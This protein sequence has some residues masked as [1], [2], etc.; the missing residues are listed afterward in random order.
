MSRD[1]RVEENWA[2]QYASKQARLNNQYLLVFFALDMEYPGS[3]YRHFD[4]MIRGLQEVESRLNDLGIPFI[5]R[6]GNPVNVIID[7]VREYKVGQLITD[8][9]PLRIKKQWKRELIFRLEIPFYEVDTHNIVP[10]WIA[11]E[12]EEYGAYTFRPKIKKLLPYFL[13]DFPD[14]LEQTIEKNMHQ[15][16]DWNF[17]HL[18]LDQAKAIP[19]V[20]KFIPGSKAAHSTLSEFIQKG[21]FRYQEQKNDPNSEAVSDLSP[22][23][24]FGHISSQQIAIEILK[25][26]G[27]D[28]NTESFLEELII[29]KE[30]SDNFCYY[31]QDY[32]KPEAFKKWA[33]ESL[34]LHAKDEREFIYSSIEFEAAQTHDPLWNAAQLE[35]KNN[36]KMHGYLRMYWAKKILEW[37]KSFPQA[38]EIANILN[39]TYSLD[40]RDPNGY[41]GCA[42]SIGGIHDRAWS[43]RPVFGKIRYMNYNGCKRKFD[44]DGYIKRI[45]QIHP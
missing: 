30:L 17:L 2:L 39:D 7:L 10:C 3:N 38:L 37:T 5:L 24:H 22:Y 1:Q 20:K 12:K 36:G 29:R 15:P 18:K 27:E 32:D 13:T 25:T 45:S 44:V 40:G 14:I 31:N 23:L 33:K 42:W 4:F 35:L 11:S 41:T 9:D 8:F 26:Y 21:L 19:R 16:V 34:A 6:H 28:E 43:D